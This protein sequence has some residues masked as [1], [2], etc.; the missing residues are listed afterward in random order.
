MHPEPQSKSTRFPTWHLLRVCYMHSFIARNIYF[1]ECIIKDLCC[2][3]H[4]E[5]EG[6]AAV[7]CSLKAKDAA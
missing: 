2:A 1:S 4:W 5:K 7:T 3:H 6:E